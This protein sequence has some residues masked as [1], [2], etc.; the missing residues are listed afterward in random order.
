MNR[1]RRWA[2]KG[3]EPQFPPLSCRRA[4][5][6]T[7]E[8]EPMRPE[9]LPLAHPTWAA[10]HR[11]RWGQREL[12]TRA[13]GGRKSWWTHPQPTHLA[14]SRTFSPSSDQ[15]PLPLLARLL[16]EASPDC[17]SLGEMSPLYLPRPCTQNKTDSPSC[18]TGPCNVDHLDYSFLIKKERALQPNT[19]G[20]LQE[21][22]GLGSQTHLGS[23]PGC[24]CG[25]G[26]VTPRHWA[27]AASSRQW[28]RVGGGERRLALSSPGGCRHSCP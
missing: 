6:L 16:W 9:G 15:K 5:L 12:G 11:V 20:I 10:P 19:V 17:L 23:S 26:R 14:W 3:P 7:T 27:S 21:E 1:E 28:G 8:L 13:H 24:K 2:F 18:P 25:L 4:A 22:Y